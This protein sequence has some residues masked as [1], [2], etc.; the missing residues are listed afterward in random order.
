MKTFNDADSVQI[1]NHL[2]ELKL[3]FKTEFPAKMDEIENLWQ[4]HTVQKKND[5]IELHRLLHNLSALANSHDAIKLSSLLYS[6][7]NTVQLIIDS[8]KHPQQHKNN[9]YKQ[10]QDTLLKID[11]TIQQWQPAKIP[12][13]QPNNSNNSTNNIY[14]LE[15]DP[16]F[17]EILINKLIYAN[18]SVTLFDDI[19][20]F[21]QV[22]EKEHPQL[23]LVD[24][25]HH[26]DDNLTKEVLLKLKNHFTSFPPIINLSEK[27]DFNTRLASI[28]AGAEYFFSKRLGFHKL[29]EMLASLIIKKDISPYKVLIISNS[30]SFSSFYENLLTHKK[31][32]TQTLNEPLKTITIID[33]F[34]PELIL[35]DLNISSCSGFELTQIIRQDNLVAITPIIFLTTIGTIKNIASKVID[36]EDE[37]LIHPV[38]K[39]HLISSIM[40]KAKK[41]HWLKS[42]YTKLD[43][44][45]RES[46]SQL[47]AMSQH[48]LVSST[49]LRGKITYV[50][51]NFC[52]VSQ[53]SAAELIGKNHRLLKSGEHP[54]SLYQNLWKTISS[55]QV[56]HG[57]ICNRKKNG[58]KYWVNSTIVPFLDNNGRPYK[59]VSVRTDITPLRLSEERLERSQV[60]ANIGTWDW[61]IKSDQITYS[62]QA[63]KILGLNA[64][65]SFYKNKT[66]LKLHPDDFKLVQ[67]AVQRCI[68][69]CDNYD[70]EY[71]IIG[72]DGSEHWMNEKGNALR[73]NNNEA[74]R[75]LG[76]IQDITEK[77]NTQLKLIS[78]RKEAEKANKSKSEFLSSMSHELRTPMNAIIGFSQLMKIDTTEPLTESQNEN[79]DEILKAS[80]HLLQLINEVL[81]LSQ[82]ETGQIDLSLEKVSVGDI[83][84]ESLQL[85]TPLVHNKNITLK[86]IFDNTSVTFEQLF[87]QNCSVYADF[88]RLKQVLLNLLSNAIKYNKEHGSVTITCSHPNK[89]QTR[90]SIQDT[91]NGLTEQQLN[92]L[93]T[94]F[95]RLGQENQEEIEGTGIG[96]VIT[97][98]IIELMGGKIGVDCIPEQGC[99]FWIELPTYV[100]DH[101]SH[102]IRNEQQHSVKHKTQSVFQQELIPEKTQSIL[103]IEDNP[104]NL[105]LVTQILARL[106]NLKIWSAPEPLLG[107]ELA[108]AHQP[109]IIL[110]DINLPGLNGFEVHKKLQKHRKTQNIPVIAISANAMPKDVEKGK[111][112]GFTQYITKPINVKVLLNTVSKLLQRNHETDT[113]Q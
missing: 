32:L 93:F 19:T 64:N 80:H 3:A 110:L 58:D 31:I 59:Y 91:G 24:I 41:T 26:K 20:E 73:D 86:L 42:I 75:M 82:I 2:F 16:L 48:N 90:I 29:T 66:H 53:Y 55:G 25:F 40:V 60:F 77:K 39:Q 94:P 46:E 30:K 49:D 28:H 54:S 87:S 57:I 22:F 72:T 1:L 111:N 69:D 14:Y 104:A 6:Q 74:L 89:Q 112:A 107:I 12:Y 108:I 7:A 70:I 27:D 23:I 51:D 71:R 11:N 67:N 36:A 105:R 52:Q 109:D 78:A 76:I 106:D 34:Q 56:W 4:L 103:Y 38:E 84:A 18:Y 45:N 15:G 61:H 10:F 50:N 13:I 21:E 8:Q 102:N 95:N 43:Y 85:I 9:L 98:K 99:N 81:D 35:L 79:T 97:K 17:A 44:L 62:A 68:Q 113:Q 37:L 5:L 83:V 63:K 100:D 65:I 33:E 101:H 96:L 88:T 47:I 92:D